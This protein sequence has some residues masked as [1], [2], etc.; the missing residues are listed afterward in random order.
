[1]LSRSVGDINLSNN[2]ML[3]TRSMS[4]WTN[5]TTPLGMGFDGPTMSGSVTPSP[6]SR[7][8]PISASSQFFQPQPRLDPVFFKESARA[9]WGRATPLGKMR[10]DGLLSSNSS[11]ADF[12]AVASSNQQSYNDKAREL[13][14]YQ[15]VKAHNKGKLLT[16]RHPGMDTFHDSVTISA[17]SI[18]SP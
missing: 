9:K 17:I 11:T 14:M 4:S 1:M 2:N 18:A 13:K 8:N 15:Q 3:N 7:P 16:T 12:N 5:G 6:L 10:V